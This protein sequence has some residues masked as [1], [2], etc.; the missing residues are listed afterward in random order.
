M[1]GA[2]ADV[3]CVA[4]GWGRAARPAEP[5]SPDTFYV[6]ELKGG[7][8]LSERLARLFRPVRTSGIHRL[9]VRVAHPA[10]AADA[11]LQQLLNGGG[12]LRHATALAQEHR[13]AERLA[14]NG[15]QRSI[16]SWW[17]VMVRGSG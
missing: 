5:L 12:H 4:P 7:E 11:V 15:R 8:K 13:I 16:G 9:L 1:P 10:I 14:T 2:V 17:P 3:H 6:G